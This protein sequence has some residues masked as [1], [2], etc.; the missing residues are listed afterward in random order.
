VAAELSALGVAVPDL[1][2]AV[3]VDGRTA[4]TDDFRWLWREFTMVARSET[5]ATW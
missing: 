2:A 1:A 3:P 4:K 5:G